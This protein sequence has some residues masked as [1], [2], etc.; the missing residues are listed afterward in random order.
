MP[1]KPLCPKCWLSI[2]SFLVVSTITAGLQRTHP[3]RPAGE[4]PSPPTPPTAVTSPHW[5]AR[6][7][8]QEGGTSLRATTGPSRRRSTVRF[9]KSGKPNCSRGEARSC[10]NLWLVAVRRFAEHGLVGAA[11]SPMELAFLSGCRAA[12]E[13]FS[14]I[15]SG[16]ASG[17]SHYLLQHLETPEEA[18]LFTDRESPCLTLR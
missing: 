6:Q 13:K 11:V 3:S 15:S 18:I 16:R 7:C 17:C 10:W 4:V 2:F 14:R 9:L 8:L 5:P 12:G 1:F